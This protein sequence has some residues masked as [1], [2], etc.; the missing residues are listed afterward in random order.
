M[1]RQSR[2]CARLSA[3]P[4]RR[5]ICGPGPRSTVQWNSPAAD[6][7]RG[8]PDHCP[9][10]SGSGERVGSGSG[11]PSWVRGRGS[12]GPSGGHQRSRG[13]PGGLRGEQTGGA[14]GRL[15]G[16]QLGEPGGG[17]GGSHGEEPGESRGESRRKS[18]RRV[19]RVGVGSTGSGGPDQRWRSGRW[20]SHGGRAMVDELSAEASSRSV[21]IK[22]PVKPCQVG[23]H[24]S[25]PSGAQRASE[26][27]TV[28][29][30]ESAVSAV[31]L[32]VTPNSPTQPCPSWTCLASLGA[33]RPFDGRRSARRSRGRKRPA[34]SAPQACQ[35]QD[36]PRA[37]RSATRGHAEGP[38]TCQMT[39]PH[40]V[41]TDRPTDDSAGH[42][43]DAPRGV[44]WDAPQ[45]HFGTLPEPPRNQA[46][47]RPGTAPQNRAGTRAQN[48]AGTRTQNHARNR[49]ARRANDVPT[50]D[51][52]GHPPDARQG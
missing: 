49:A 42:P 3:P 43:P 13:E 52:A 37:A 34:G 46:Q 30:A 4:P 10:G 11:R 7:S 9:A 39:G 1:V 29:V 47:N 15:R 36:G 38:T 48:R 41:P 51:S 35:P 2:V 22:R 50:D 24:A 40:D 27:R 31:T 5:V 45:M 16:E 8:R 23:L 20:P 28:A 25:C 12:D 33:Q 19:V 44:T 21:Y 6:A 32:R 26:S 17:Y 18:Y 14:R